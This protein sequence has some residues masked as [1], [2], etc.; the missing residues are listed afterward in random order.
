MFTFIF[1]L[2]T[3]KRTSMFRSVSYLALGTPYRTALLISVL[4]VHH[5]AYLKNEVDLVWLSTMPWFRR[6]TS[7]STLVPKYPT[8]CVTLA[9]FTTWS[10]Q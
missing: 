5:S 6:V 10:C 9:F 3:N 2:T 1:T 8:L 4:G 7:H